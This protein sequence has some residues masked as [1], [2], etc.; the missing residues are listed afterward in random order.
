MTRIT[1]ALTLAVTALM[2]MAVNV[3]AG[4][5]PKEIRDWFKF[6]EGTWEVRL[7]GDDNSGMPLG[8]DSAELAAGGTVLI[9]KG[10]LTG[11]GNEYVVFQAWE[12][13]KKKLVMN[14][15]NADSAHSRSELDA[16]TAELKGTIMGTDHEGA[17]FVGSEVVKRIDDNTIE[18][19]FDGKLGGNALSW[20]LVAK[21]KK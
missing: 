7:K 20:T 8:I 2:S 5:I 12:A 14:W 19:T 11:T 1:A 10:K 13:E 21:R 6:S 15:Y 9:T 18:T 3:H 4:E 16:T 17:T